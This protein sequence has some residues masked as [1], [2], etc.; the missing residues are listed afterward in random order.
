MTKI[1]ALLDG[2]IY[3][4]SVCHHAAWAAK[5]VDAEV[6]LLHLIK[7]ETADRKDYS[8]SIKLGARTR[9]MDELSTLDEQR[10]KLSQ[11]HGRAILEDGEAI[12]KGDA[13]I[14]VTARLR[15]GD[16]VETVSE[17]ADAGSLIMIGKRGEDADFNE[18][19]LGSNLERMVRAAK[20]PVFVANREFKEIKTVM[21]AFDGGESSLKAVNYV[22]ENALFDGLN[23]LV[24]TIGDDATA[25][26]ANVDGAKS[27][28]EKAGRSVET[29]VIAGEP[30]VVLG[31]LSEDGDADILVMGAYGHSR[32][33]TLIIG[34]TTTAMIRSCHIPVVLMK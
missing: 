1:I 11:S 4:E 14:S 7:R 15:Y 18:G 13:D 23:V 25:H 2:S 32:I 8:G 27:I 19:H 6:E 10:A 16:V 9:L 29:R 28:L 5:R 22:A 21:I 3:S 24:V 33:R 34:S 30:E 31:K 26:K 17:M 20:T 12:V